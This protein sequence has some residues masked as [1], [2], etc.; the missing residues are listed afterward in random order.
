MSIGDRVTGALSSGFYRL[1]ARVA[2]RRIGR[3]NRQFAEPPHPD[4]T[5]L[6]VT[7]PKAASQW[8]QSI[9]T[10]L[11]RDAVVK[12]LPEAGSVKGGNVAHGK[13]YTSLYLTKDE[14]SSLGD[15]AKMRSFFVMRDLRDSLVSLYFSLSKT[16]AVTDEHVERGRNVL[17][18][19]GKE[20]GLRALIEQNAYNFVRIQSSW[21]GDPE[22]CYRFED[23]VTEPVKHFNT[24]L[25]EN[26]GLDIHPARLDGVCQKYSFERMSGGRSKGQE[27]ASSHLRSG[28]PGNWRE[29]FTPALIARFKELHGGHLV[30]CGYETGMDW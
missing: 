1:G 29:H 24:I 14:V 19:L 21:L 12:N 26:L 18:G 25:H 11:Y 20:D 2:G 28:K 15:L 9:L 17:A 27:D 13:F 5:Y 30:A 16:H 6:H 23:L 3:L 4:I 7:H 10:D 22:S 8:V